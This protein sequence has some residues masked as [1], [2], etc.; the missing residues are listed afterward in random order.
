MATGNRALI[1][2]STPHSAIAALPA[3]LTAQIVP[4]R[5]AASFDAVLFEG[6]PAA[7]SALC[8]DLATRPGAIVTVQ[9]ER[10]LYRPEW[11]LR[12]RSLSI[13][14]TAAGGNASLMSIG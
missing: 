9:T 1:D 3:D 11:L 6:S 4:D 8:Q 2:P 7:Q 5:A 12:E 10:T 13:N 14:T